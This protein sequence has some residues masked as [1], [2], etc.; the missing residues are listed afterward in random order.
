MVVGP[1]WFGKQ[2]V[3][4]AGFVVAGERLTPMMMLAL[5]G[6]GCAVLVG[7]TVA[8]YQMTTGHMP[9]GEATM[10]MCAGMMCPAG[11]ANA[12]PTNGTTIAMRSIAFSPA[13]LSVRVGTTVTW[14]NHDGVA[15]TVTSDDASG[16]LASPSIAPGASWSF[17]FRSA[18]S[19]SY[20]CVPHASRGADGSYQGMTGVVDVG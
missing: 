20:H 12:G 5:A 17:T 10:P 1:N 19:F 16:P 8:G 2:S 15:H 14:V 3:R 11:A 4:R 9:W 6:L 18:G 13:A 7:G